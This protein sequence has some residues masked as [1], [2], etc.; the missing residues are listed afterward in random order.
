M[1]YVK[2][3]GFLRKRCS[4]R[5]IPKQPALP[6]PK[7]CPKCKSCQWNS[8]RMRLPKADPYRNDPALARRATQPGQTPEAT[9]R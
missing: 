6:E 8:P 3:D 2:I 7:V 4:H 9:A 5:W 1:A